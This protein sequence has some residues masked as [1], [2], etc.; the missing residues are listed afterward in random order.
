PTLRFLARAGAS[1]GHSRMARPAHGSRLYQRRAI[2]APR[3]LHRS[4]H[5]LV[6]G[7]DVTAVDG[8]TW[9]AKCRGALC[10]VRHADGLADMG[11]NRELIVLNQQQ[12]WQLPERRHVT[13]L[14]ENAL[15]G[16][17]LSKKADRDCAAWL[18]L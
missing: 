1:G 18:K 11:S 14:V 8:D 2:A 9:K 5:R 10:N 17:P 13:R 15:A 3:A 16:S 4:G 6:Y 12:Q 7:V